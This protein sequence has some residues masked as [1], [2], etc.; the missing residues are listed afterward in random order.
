M[1]GRRALYGRLQDTQKRPG[2]GD[3][4]CFVETGVSAVGDR[5]LCLGSSVSGRGR[6]NDDGCVP[7]VAELV[8]KMHAIYSWHGEIKGYYVGQ[9]IYEH[10]T[11]GG[12]IA[13]STYHSTARLVLDDL[14][15]HR[16]NCQRVVDDKNSQAIHT[17]AHNLQQKESLN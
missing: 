11:S 5:P 17:R 4:F 3:E 8:E 14:L 16:T 10:A 15:D 2:V 1:A 12:N 9:Q 7:L 13:G 6:E